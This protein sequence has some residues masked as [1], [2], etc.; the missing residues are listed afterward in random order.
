MLIRKY[1]AGL[2]LWFLPFCASANDPYHFSE[3]VLT[4][5]TDRY[6]V[7]WKEG[8][9][10]GARTFLP[11]ERSLTS[12]VPGQ[13]PGL[14]PNGPGYRHEGGDKPWEYHAWAET[15]MEG[16]RFKVNRSPKPEGEVKFERTKEG[17]TVSYIFPSSDLR[18]IQSFRVDPQSGDLVISQRAVSAK[19][20]LS[21]IA[22]G[23]YNLDA[24]I[25]LAV[26]TFPGN[27]QIWRASH[28]KGSYINQ[29]Y[30]VFWPAGIVVGMVPEGGSFAI[31]SH[32]DQLMPKY[33]RHYTDGT[34]R[35]LGFDASLNYPYDGNTEIEVFSWRFNTFEGNWTQ[36]ATRYR[37]HLQT[38]YS[39]QPLAERS[40]KWLDGLAMIWS[41]GEGTEEQLAKMAGRIP[42]EKVV[43]W[44]F[45]GSTKDRG[46][47]QKV[48]SYIP[49]NGFVE[50]N[51]RARSLGFHVAAY[52]SMALVD[53]HEHPT[54]ME[55]YG[56][57]FYY[58]ALYRSEIKEATTRLT[59][60]HPGSQ[61][62]RTF[63]AGRMKEV[64]D[65][66]GVDVLYQDVSGTGP[67]S[68]G[69]VEGLN[70]HQAVVAADSD[71]HA[72]V[73]KAALAGEYW[74]EVTMI[75]ESIGLQRSLGWGRR[76]QINRM[77]RMDQS[78]PILSLLF[79][80]FSY[81]FGYKVP[82][83]DNERW[84]RDQNMNEVIGSLPDWRGDVDDQGPEAR[85]T[86]LRAGL[87]ADGFKPWF[88]QEWKAGVASYMRNPK[89]ETVEYRR[90][91]EVS[92]CIRIDANG[93]ESLV[94]GRFTGLGELAYPDPVSIDQWIAYGKNGPIGLDPDRYYCFFPGAPQN[95]PLV[96]DS[97]PE[98]G[99][100]TTYR[101][102]E[103]LLFVGLERSSGKDFSFKVNTPG[104]KVERGGWGTHSY[105]F[106]SK[107]VVERLEMGAA[108]SVRGW[109][110]VI[111]NQGME[112]GR[113]VSYKVTS[114]MLEGERMEALLLVP[115]AGGKGAEGVVERMV[116]LP[117][118]PNLKLAFHVGRN[119]GSGDGV[120]CVV[121]VN[122]QEV[123]RRF[124][125]S[126]ARW[127][128]EVVDLGQFAGKTV[129]L[130]LA[131]DAGPDGFNRSNDQMYL[132][133][134]LLT[135]EDAPTS[136]IT[137]RQTHD[138]VTQKDD[139]TFQ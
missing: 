84:H 85:I 56:L 67:G 78:H 57:G 33:L 14:L 111:T 112:T 108:I 37:D 136:Q 89:G 91:G 10:T 92:T 119:G 129:L 116:R 123:W 69:V 81:Y 107:E 55:Q 105:L 61:K 30:P 16:V 94:Y 76:G 25:P 29:A 34:T 87:F 36:P 117:E 86:L 120:H 72:K 53:V 28:G 48:P 75:R 32:D 79:S 132:A 73:P 90:K 104:L 40:P 54:M 45:S 93:K 126:E 130:S 131:V 77:S 39:I 68:S 139:L 133:G 5:R 101:H 114:R 3:G 70:F 2:A 64:Y 17:A 100:V 50:R 110:H 103:G 98:G 74:N 102:H 99:S 8:A 62:W 43:L 24:A 59:Y 83:G 27:G 106:A 51:R 22:F 135:G 122:G 41:T 128:R 58:D 7:V 82:F 31:W 44:H 134:L 65:N 52:Y 38:V 46:I 12:G 21:G 95:L 13:E 26:P 20:G 121:R 15:P 4:I 80:P 66:Y 113:P 71:I 1:F 11:V 109:S 96:I 63:Y 97:L 88:P 137:E 138:G 18:W 23:V 115:P 49:E 35:A 6:E 125:P 47:N 19:P 9:M 118:D 42:P 127:R 124:S 60:V